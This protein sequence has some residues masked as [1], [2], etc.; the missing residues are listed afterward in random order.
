M[1]I[2]VYIYDVYI[3]YIYDV[4]IYIYSEININKFRDNKTFWKRI[5]PF[6]SN[7][8]HLSTRITLTGKKA[9]VFD[10]EKV[11]ETLSFREY[12]NISNTAGYSEP[13]EIAVMI[14]S[15]VMLL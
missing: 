14:T 11:T 5:T 10:D 4:N 3:I 13:L 9:T 7:K 2:Y 15:Q 6:L 8:V 12:S 1:C